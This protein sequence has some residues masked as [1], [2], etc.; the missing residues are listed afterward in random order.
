MLFYI[1]NQVLTLL[2]IVQSD[3]WSSG[4]YRWKWN[5]QE[6]FCYSISRYCFK[7]WYWFK[8]FSSLERFQ[9]IFFIKLNMTNKLFKMDLT[10]DTFFNQLLSII[11]QNKRKEI[12]IKTYTYT[13]NIISV[14]SLAVM[15]IRLLKKII[16]IH[17]SW[18][19]DSILISYKTFLSI[20]K[21]T[22]VFFLR[23]SGEYSKRYGQVSVFTTD[24]WKRILKTDSCPYLIIYSLEVLKKKTNVLDI[25]NMDKNSIKII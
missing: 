4:I 24:P 12:L 9:D 10:R 17:I 19:L 7:C 5:N 22:L 8:I 6:H 23:T 3:Y 15:G 20:L 1:K 13:L 18:G 2:I 21:I 16:L 25:S 14:L 11:Y